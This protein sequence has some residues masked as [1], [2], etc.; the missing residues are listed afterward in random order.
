MDSS[1]EE[2]IVTAAMAKI[3]LE[4]KLRKKRKRKV[5]VDLWLQRRSYLGV[6]NTLLLKMKLEDQEDYKN[7]IF[8]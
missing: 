7:L 6:F 5:W 4:N 2:V 8:V 1:D 3:V